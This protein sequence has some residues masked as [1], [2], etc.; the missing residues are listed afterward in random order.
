MKP[1]AY[2]TRNAWT[3]DKYKVITDLLKGYSTQKRKFGHNLLTLKLLQTC[4]SFLSSAEHKGGYFEERQLFG[5][6][7]FHC[8]KI[9]W[10]SMGPKLQSFFKMLCV[11]QQK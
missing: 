4:M 11:Q 2:L 7:D 3:T 1:I 10:K 9:L 6:I 5:T 8:I